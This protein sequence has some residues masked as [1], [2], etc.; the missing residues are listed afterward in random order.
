[1]NKYIEIEYSASKLK[2]SEIDLDKFKKQ[3]RTKLEKKLNLCT[4]QDINTWDNSPF[5]D[6]NLSD[7]IKYNSTNVNSVNQIIT[8]GSSIGGVNI[9]EEIITNLKG[10]RGY[11]PIVITQHILASFANNM[12]DRMSKVND[13]FEYHIVNGPIVLKENNIY[14][15]NGKNHMLVE[16]NGT[17]N[18]ITI[19]NNM[20]TVNKHIPSINVLYR[21][22]ANIYGSKAIALILTGMGKDGIVG[23]GELYLKGAYTIAQNKESSVVH[24]MAGS[25]IEEGFIKEELTVKKI[26]GKINYLTKN[27]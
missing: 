16:K 10:K 15:S 18:I 5:T 24:G 13:N 20:K 12:V 14:F 23:M 19:S 9:I 22:I 17:E 8:I 2:D 25:S 6:E 3:I 7:I 26:I 27:F 4:R 21:S 1:M 11:P